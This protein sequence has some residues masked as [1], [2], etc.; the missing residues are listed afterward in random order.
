MEGILSLLINRRELITFRITI[1]YLYLLPPSFTLYT[2]SDGYD[3]KG[4][5]DT[6]Y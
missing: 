5:K 4:R 1:S 6:H 2:T 3:V